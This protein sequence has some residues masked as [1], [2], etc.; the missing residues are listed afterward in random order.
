M[1]DGEFAFLRSLIITES[2][3][4]PLIFSNFFQLLLGHLFATVLPGEPVRAQQSGGLEIQ[5]SRSDAVS[6]GRTEQDRCRPAVRR[7]VPAD[8]RRQVGLLRRVALQVGSGNLSA[9]EVRD[10]SGG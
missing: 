4:G 10:G 5:L 8:L 7:P 9:H 1:D 2:D 3:S 6:G